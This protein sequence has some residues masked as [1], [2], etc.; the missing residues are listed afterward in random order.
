MPFI[1]LC[2][3]VVSG[4]ERGCQTLASE[5]EEKWGRAVD[6]QQLAEVIAEKSSL[7]PGDVHNVIRT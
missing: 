6:A 7:T 2:K 5:F 4:D 1:L 3:T